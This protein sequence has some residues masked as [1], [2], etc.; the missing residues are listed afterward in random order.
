MNVKS[1]SVSI[2][3][4]S[5]AR[6]VAKGA[7]WL[8]SLFCCLFALLFLALSNRL[9]LAADAPFAPLLITGCVLVLTLAHT[10]LEQHEARLKRVYPIILIVF[11]LSMLAFE[12]LAANALRYQPWADWG[13]LYDLGMIYRG[14]LSWADAGD[15][16][17]YADFFYIY[18]YNL[19]EM[20]FLSV[21]FSISHAVGITD[22]FMVACFTNI[23][24]IVT[25]VVLACEICRKEF[26][27]PSALFAMVLFTLVR[28]LWYMG[29]VFYTDSM[30][31]LYPVL[32]LFLYIKLKSA[33]Q[34]MPRIVY[35]VLIG[36]VAAFGMTIKMT[37]LVM[38]VAVVA[39]SLFDMKW[40]RAIAV[41]VVA[42]SMVCAGYLCFQAVIYPAH[43][44]KEIADRRN[45]PAAH[46]VMEGLTGSG[47]Y[48][49]HDFQF[50][51]SFTDPDERDKAIA[52]EISNRL[53]SLGPGGLYNMF[54][55]KTMRGF[56][57][58]TFET[59]HYF[60]RTPEHKTDR[61]TYLYHD[62]ENYPTYNAAC[63]VV[64]F[65]ILALMS[66]SSLRVLLR[67]ARPVAKSSSQANDGS[68]HSTS[69]SVQLDDTL[70]PQ[71]AIFGAAILFS[72]WESSGRYM[73][74]S[75]PL[76][77]LSAAG[78]AGVWRVVFL[79]AKRMFVRMFRAFSGARSDE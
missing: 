58:A 70:A 66:L 79:K 52:E 3:E 42:G 64:W 5:L 71:L 2:P 15:F 31:M 77:V 50:T 37:V 62:G 30:S 41:T 1:Y 20:A 16:S 73:I 38:I 53:S 23:V 46:F 29:L 55:I 69:N 44:D 34:A 33:S 18:P 26:G 25:A 51:H 12:L 65:T 74:N 63:Q 72:A 43:L 47:A 10:L 75:I 78:G 57:R 28:P 76:I 45:T 49:G 32:I 17:E 8:E 68:L 59:E 40:R 61:A 13:G 27:Y 21:V 7:A 56:G 24:G 9:A 6:S 4:S 14:A 39:D 22:D 67:A 11:A 54:W 60:Q 35:L 19:G 48:N 36:L